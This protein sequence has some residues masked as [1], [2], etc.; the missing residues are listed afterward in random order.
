MQKTNNRTVLRAEPTMVSINGCVESQ[1]GPKQ[2]RV[3][4]LARRALALFEPGLVVD[5]REEITKIYQEI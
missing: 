5:L 4:V 1:E 2:D 3:T